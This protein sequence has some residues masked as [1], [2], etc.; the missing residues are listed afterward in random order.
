MSTQW[1]PNGHPALNEKKKTLVLGH[2]HYFRP[3]K[4]TFND[5]CAFGAH[6]LLDFALETTEK[7]AVRKCCSFRAEY[8]NEQKSVESILL[9]AIQMTPK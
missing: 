7:G 1:V 5:K 9:G 6:I 3:R 4:W 2:L 8:W